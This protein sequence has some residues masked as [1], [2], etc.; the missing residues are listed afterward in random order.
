MEELIKVTKVC[1][2]GKVQIPVEIRSALCLND[3]DKVAWF[4]NDYGVCYIKKV[5][6]V[7]GKVGKYRV[8]D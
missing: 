1:A 4:M 3:G 2:R 5:T 6:A 7:M 8:V